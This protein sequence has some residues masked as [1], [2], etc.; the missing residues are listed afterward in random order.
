MIF[1]VV[2]FYGAFTTTFT[3]Y[4]KK[5]L[6]ALDQLSTSVC[7]ASLCLGVLIYSSLNEQ[8]DYLYYL[9]FFIIIAINMVFLLNMVYLLFEGYLDK[10]QVFYLNLF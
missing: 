10:F 7:A 4:K 9:M 1:L 3:P 5:K 2:F 6:N 8:L